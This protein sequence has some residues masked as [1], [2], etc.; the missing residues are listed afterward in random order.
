MATSV[1]PSPQ[2]IRYELDS[3]GEIDVPSD[4]LRGAQT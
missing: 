3:L 2:I 1:A 4:V